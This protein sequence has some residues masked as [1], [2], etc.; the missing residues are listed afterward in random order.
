MNRKYKFCMK[1]GKLVE[2]NW[3]SAEN[4]SLLTNPVKVNEIAVEE[5]K[6]KV[7]T[8]TGSIF[9]E[10]NDLFSSILS[11]LS[12][13]DLSHEKYGKMIKILEQIIQSTNNI[14]VS[15]AK[16]NKQYSED[17]EKGRE[18]ML[19]KLEEINTMRKLKKK[20]SSNPLFVEVEE[21]SVGLKWKKSKVNKETNIPDHKLE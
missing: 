5:N 13:L 4:V 12:S 20:I 14:C 17:L 21:V 1:E 19:K 6:I 2:C 11:D 9:K 8:S 15:V 16:N 10:A 7:L 18:F 3:W